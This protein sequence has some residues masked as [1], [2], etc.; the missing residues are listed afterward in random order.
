[1]LC[2]L[3]LVVCAVC[4]EG[5]AV[6][7]GYEMLFRSETTEVC[8]AC[9]EAP[10]LP[11]WLEGSYLI[12]AIGQ[13]EIGE[14]KFVD[15]LDGFGKLHRVDIKPRAGLPSEICL[16]ARMMDTAFY[17]E[18]L[19]K[20]KIAP[21]V[22][23]NEPVPP[24]KGLNPLR[25]IMGPNDNVLINSVELGKGQY[26]MVTD[27]PT[28]LDV[29]PSTLRML[30]KHR[31]SDKTVRPG[32]MGML[33]SGHPLRWPGDAQKRLLELVVEAPYV[34]VGHHGPLASGRVDVLAVSDSAPEQRALLN[35]YLPPRGYLPYFHSFGA[36]QNFAVLPL[37]AVTMGLG[38]LEQGRP[39][40]EAFAPFEAK[41]IVLLPL[42]GSAPLQFNLSA[43]ISYAHNVNAYE[44]ASGVVF[45]VT[46]FNTANP[47]S[48]NFTQI[49][50]QLNKAARDSQH[51]R[52]KVERFVLHMATGAV[53]SE[54]LTNSPHAA[55]GRA[56]FQEFPRIDDARAGR[57]YAVYYALEWYH[58]DM[59]KGAMA[60]AKQQVPVVGREGGTGAGTSYW[61]R[62][63]F[64]P[65]EALF[66]ASDREGR[67]EDEG[68]LLF[69]S[70]AGA[71]QGQRSHFHIVN[72][73][74][75]TDIVD[76]RLPVRVPYQA[77]GQF[78]AG[79][80]MFNTSSSETETLRNA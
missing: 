43:T 22:L 56:R 52:G 8:N 53:T 63:A 7:E 17:N 30:G 15:V 76:L 47:F 59:T 16:S 24:R 45:D 40:S 19:A 61:Y 65:S 1:M 34:S 74:T 35:S 23:F 60:I 6:D 20:G 67:R 18:S 44:N 33:G 57:E 3:A 69:L 13:L 26:M 4:G 51:N 41:S 21:S 78:Y 77:H 5:E 75:M 25:N 62:K 14:Q 29:S 49:S 46:T 80:A 27:S 38:V 48:N 50:V 70:L 66:V 68:A 9:Y 2:A 71:E 10:S 32:N 28:S 55:Q 11:S 64:Y 58:D 12:A 72:A 37:Q 73:T 39:M 54:T 79:T 31:W 36:T 42:N